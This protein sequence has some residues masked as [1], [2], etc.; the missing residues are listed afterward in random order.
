MKPKYTPPALFK[1]SLFLILIFTFSG[2]AQNKKQPDLV[3][4]YK[5]YTELPREISY[6]HLNKTTYLKGE[7][8]GYT[9]YVFDKLSK[10]PSPRTTN[11]YCTISDENDRIVKSEMI[12]AANGIANGS[13]QIDSLFT[14]G[15]YTFKAYT[16]WMRNFDEHNYYTQTIKILN[17][18]A[19]DTVKNKT[20]TLKLDAQFLPEGG[21]F[22]ADVK[23]SVGVIVKDSLGFGVPNVTGKVIDSES[24][25]VIDFKTNSLGIG[26]FTFLPNENELYSAIINFNGSEQ[27]F[28]IQK[29]ENQGI[30]LTLN[31][32]GTR[33]ALSFRTNKNTFEQIKNND[34]TLAIHNGNVLRTID[35]NFGESLE[36]IKMINSKD[37]NTGINIF[38]LFD[39][40]SQPIM[41]R[42]FFKYDGIKLLTAQKPQITNVADSLTVKIPINNINTALVNN[43]SVSVLPVETKSYNPN[44]NIISETYLQ[45]YIKSY[46]ENAAYYFTDITRKKKFEL[47]NVLLTQGWSSYD[48]NSIFNQPP[49]ELYEFENG[50][51]F[52]ANINNK[53]A[54]EYMMY[55][56]MNNEMEVFDFDE[57]DK[58]FGAVGL[59]PMETEKIKF[60]AIKKNKDIAKPSL[61]FQ[62]S[63]SAI[64]S[65]NKTGFHVPLNNKT[66]SDTYSGQKIS[67]TS[68]GKA[69]QLKEVVIHANKTISREDKLT[70]NAFGKVKVINDQ[71]RK[72]T[73]LLSDYIRTQGFKVYEM[74][75]QLII[76]NPRPTSFGQGETITT[77]GTLS[78]STNTVVKTK[79]VLVYFNDIKL[80]N[81]DMLYKYTMDD[82]DYILFDKSGASEGGV[83]APGVIKIYTDP[84]LS[85]SNMKRNISQEVSVPLAFSSPKKFY[86]PEYT[87]Y[88]G[89]FYEDYGVIGWFPRLTIQDDGNIHFKVQRQLIDSLSVFIEGTANDGSFIS[90]RKTVTIP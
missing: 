65:L 40:N 36:V 46:I 85:Q 26:K 87:S 88:Q 51:S 33:V 60:S 73:V 50:I 5:E 76:T 19:E 68:W 34:Y 8:L 28:T 82:V 10:K 48:W 41:E 75:G 49:K 30:A 7:I 44:N 43:F 59:Y 70:R 12:L 66:I 89:Q 2:F 6:A 21:H 31:D 22:V 4:S 17:S 62:F 78:G 58:D 3:T 13:F 37:L 74:M 15:T 71:I 83:G 55:A 69:E 42:L 72:S 86:T 80:G 90:E 79:P 25:T 24:N 57:G 18:E 64:P 47:D 67:N 35:I 14:S 16:N 27:K 45:P 61:Y 52:R 38:T 11:V 23:N 56:S 84:S 54:P 32:L 20:T 77:K 1:L 29:T 63:P 39:E 53:P 81:T 9:T